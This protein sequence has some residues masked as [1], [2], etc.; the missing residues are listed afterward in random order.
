MA[1]LPFGFSLPLNTS[2]YLSRISDFMSR[3]VNYVVCGF[4][5]GFAL[6]ASELN[7]IQERFLVYQTLS[8]RCNNNW[9]ASTTLTAPNPFWEGATPFS[10]ANISTTQ[11][12]GS[13]TVFANAG[14]YYVIDSLAGGGSVSNS[15]FG[16]WINIKTT[17]SV[18]VTFNETSTTPL[19]YGF[20][21]SKSYVNFNDDSSLKDNSNSSNSSLN[22]PGAD[23]MKIVVDSLSSRTS[24]TT[25]NQGKFC[26]LF[27]ATRTE[28]S[29]FTLSWPYSSSA[30]F[31]TGTN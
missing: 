2:T 4:K 17:L 20:M 30:V 8:N 16:Y 10:P 11:T 12:A 5:P 24:V 23:R 22:V 21:L 6:Q 3:P 19:K 18:T 26:E 25:Q 1:E 31:A 14:W 9:R 13:I 27:N 7:E 29:R 28:L 15:G